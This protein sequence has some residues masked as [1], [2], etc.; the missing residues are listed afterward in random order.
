M[1]ALVPVSLPIIYLLQAA[2]LPDV[3]PLHMAEV[4]MSGLIER[5]EQDE[6]STAEAQADVAPTPQTE[7]TYQFVEGVRELLVDAVP[8]T[9]AESVLDRVSQYIG[10]KLGRSIYSFTALLLLE[11]EL[12]DESGLELAKFASLTKQVLR[13]MGG[14]YAALVDRLEDPSGVPGAAYAAPPDIA[15]EI[16]PLQTL[17][18]ITGQLVEAGQASSS[19]PP[20]QTEEFT[21]ATVVL[22]V[23]PNPAESGLEVC[24]FTVATLVLGPIPEG[25][26]QSTSN[27]RPL[28]KRPPP[29][30][31]GP[32]SRSG[33][34]TSGQQQNIGWL[35]QRQQR[36]A[37]R[38]LDMFT[39]GLT[40]EM[41]SIPAG[42]FTMGSPKQEPEHSDRE[43]PQHEVTVDAFLMGRYPITQTQ[44][45]FVAQLPQVNQDLSL[46]PSH[47]KGENRPVEGVSWHDAVE[48]CD[49][50]SA[51]TG[52]EYRLPSE[53]EW[54]YACRAGTTTPFHFGETITSALA[55][56][57]ASTAYNNGL[58][59]EYR[60]ETTPVDRFGIAN[61]FGL[62]DMH[63]NVWE[64]CQDHWHDDYKGA[65][66]DGSAWL[67][68]N[69]NARRVRRGGSWDSYPWYCRAAYRSSDYPRGASFYT[70]FR[71]VCSAPRPF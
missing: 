70:G 28:S 46:D 65:P 50:L 27:I 68:E 71:V 60:R 29:L 26:S 59:G 55:N 8:K 56:Y 44:W 45:R 30:S 41:V 23:T 25:Q 21:I 10:E 67:N 2:M 11:Q 9:V 13:R 33:S 35:V 36:Q 49:R 38:L 5:E 37:Y 1:M 62:S 7:T 51:Y 14:N 57:D 34:R 63:G 39:D 69:E 31:K 48:F 42:N 32:L 58:K 54:E 24:E 40:L 20:L 61:A 47:F 19:F 43:G 3:T 18:F 4:F 53:A 17:D 6:P 22:E 15:F 12:G 16:P 66:A 64:W 52:R